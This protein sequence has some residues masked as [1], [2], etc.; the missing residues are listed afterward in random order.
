[1]REFVEFFADG[2]YGKVG[3][4]PGWPEIAVAALRP[5]GPKVIDPW[6]IPDLWPHSVKFEFDYYPEGLETIQAQLR[7]QGLS[8][9]YW[10]RCEHTAAEV[11][12]AELLVTGP[13]RVLTSVEDTLRWKDVT[14]CR[15]CGTRTAHWQY[16]SLQIVEP[17]QGAELANVDHWPLVCSAELAQALRE[18]RV[19][20]LALVPVGP[21]WPVQWYGLLTTH[22]LP[23][24]ATSPTRL[25]PDPVRTPQCLAHHLWDA[26][27]PLVYRRQELGAADF[28]HTYEYFGGVETAVR[29]LVISQRV[30]R[31][32][33]E[34]GF[35]RRNGY[36]VDV[37]D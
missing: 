5:L 32:F 7:R 19:T 14:V 13:G 37:V 6:P 22:E 2:E 27:T 12:Q 31:L 15:Y 26:K 11:R 30:Y 25:V 21:D 33:G 18:A 28:N 36:P 29:L 1:M 10:V 34:V 24:L 23:P 17:P 8:V 35:K 9:D 20:G 3:S 4:P 16:E